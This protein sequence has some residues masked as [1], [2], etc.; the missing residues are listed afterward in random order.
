MFII[1]LLIIAGVLF[2][3]W[4]YSLKYG[5]WLVCLYLMI[6]IVGILILRIV[7]Y[8]LAAS[9]GVSFWL[10]P[11]MLGDYGFVDSLRPFYSVE[12]W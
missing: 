2:P 11:N 6:L 3:L 4:P 9:F 10:L 1:V 8:I 7:L 5:V 12:R